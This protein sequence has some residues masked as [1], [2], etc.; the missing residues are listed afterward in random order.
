MEYRVIYSENT[1]CHEGRQGMRWYHR[2]YQNPDGTWTELGKKR[3]RSGP[4]ADAKKRAE[5]KNEMKNLKSKSELDTARASYKVTKA[6]NKKAVREARGDNDKPS[7]KERLTS[8]LSSKKETD[9]EKVIRSGNAAQVEKN[10]SQ[11]TDE[12]LR[13]A[14]NRIQLDNQL[15]AVKA[16]QTQRGIDA[17]K[18]VADVANTTASLAKNT[19]DI[20]NSIAKIMNTFGS[21]SKMKIIGEKSESAASAALS[22][23]ERMARLRISEANAERLEAANRSLSS[24]NQSSTQTSSGS[25]SSTRSE[26]AGTARSNSSSSTTTS[27]SRSTSSSGTQTNTARSQAE[28]TVRDASSTRMSDVERSRYQAIA[29]NDAFRQSMHM[30]MA[31]VMR[32]NRRRGIVP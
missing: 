4:S 10:K 9:K 3:R 31:D 13:Q 16:Q 1:L 14:I 7:I 15:S 29:N 21:D 11:M 8:K 19:I 27:Q 30:T 17:Y 24:G 18:R 12:E 2:R 5:R 6:L 25:T 22:A 20:Y 26:P 32:E 23:R 28:R